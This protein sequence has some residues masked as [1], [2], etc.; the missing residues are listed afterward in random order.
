MHQVSLAELEADTAPGDVECRR[1]TVALEMEHAAI[2]HYQ[3][4]PGEGLPAGLH[5]HVDQEEIFLVCEGRAIFE[6]LAGEI[7]VEAGE[8]IRFEPGEFQ[9]G[10][11][12]GEDPLVLL[13]VGAPRD[14]EDVRI[15]ASCPACGNEKLGLETDGGVR[16]VCPGCAE[17]HVP[18]DCPECGAGGMYMTLDEAGDPVAACRDCGA[19]FAEPPLVQ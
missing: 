1:L 13:A 7:P 18:A 8:A 15:P 19:T 16:F 4:P 17:E 6:T 12:A 10:H 5:A 9:S 11:N 2:N 3:V 14:S